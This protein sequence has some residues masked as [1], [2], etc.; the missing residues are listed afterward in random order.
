MASNSTQAVEA[1]TSMKAG[2]EGPRVAE[3][4]MANDA[5]CRCQGHMICECNP[6][7]TTTG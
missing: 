4:H 3:I 6:P 7:L 2:F 5:D 1:T